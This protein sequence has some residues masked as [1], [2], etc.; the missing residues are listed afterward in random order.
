MVS[1]WTV[2]KNLEKPANGDYVNTWS[3][4]VNAD[5]D[6]IDASLGGTATINATGASGTVS[7]SVGQYRPINMVISGAPVGDT[8]YQLPSGVGGF[9]TVSNQTTGGFNI[10]LNSAGGGTS[11]VLPVGRTLT[12]SDGTNVT[13]A[14]ST[15][16]SVSSV[17]AS[18]GA[19]G[20]TFSGGPITTSGTLTMSG[21][22]AVGSGG[23]GAITAGAARANLGAAASGANSD[24][25]S[26]T[27]LT[28][29][30]AISEGGTGT[31]TSAGARTNLGLGTMAVQDASAVAI[32]GGAIQVTPTSGFGGAYFNIPPGATP[33]T[34]NNGDMFSTST[35]L[36]ARIAGTTQQLATSTTIADNSIGINQ[37]W[38]AVTRVINTSYQNTT[39]K[40]IMVAIE[41]DNGSGV[42]LAQVSTD[43]ATWVTLCNGNFYPTTSFIVPPNHYYRLN[44]P[45]GSTIYYWAEL[46]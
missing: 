6:A 33:P 27:G 13:T 11:V 43:N 10:Y 3:T 19:T 40:P 15:A 31:T 22:L 44:A 34:L 7:L 5:W 41:F 1:T 26:L 24:I 4:P 46:R 14:V 18:G 21:T 28:T 32:T 42:T 29:P 39:G 36:F 38:Q 20:F 16:A 30:L 25:T 2:N 35:G 8:A 17:N 37:S 23:T 9:W 12:V 45:G